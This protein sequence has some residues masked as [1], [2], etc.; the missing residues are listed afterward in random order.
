VE[1]IARTF[2]AERDT[3]KRQSV[4]GVLSLASEQVG[5]KV[6]DLVVTQLLS[7]SKST[8]SRGTPSF[9]DTQQQN[10]ELPCNA[11]MRSSGTHVQHL[12][13]ASRSIYHVTQPILSFFIPS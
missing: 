13:A 6:T 1:K 4:C 8:V 3:L 9:N 2:L 12:P 10:S 5:E 11:T 7:V